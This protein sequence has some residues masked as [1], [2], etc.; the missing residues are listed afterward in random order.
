MVPKAVIAD[1]SPDAGD[2]ESSSVSTSATA[3]SMGRS[4]SVNSKLS[5]A[6]PDAQRKKLVKAFLDSNGFMHVNESKSS[7]TRTC[8]PLHTAVRQNKPAIVKALL[9]LGARA[10]LKSRGLTPEEY[11]LQRQNKWGGYEGTVDVFKQFRDQEISRQ[12]IMEDSESSGSSH[13]I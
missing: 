5:E 10:D 2:A 3:R 13:S 9:L 11:A 6:D 7:W 12:S 8:Y 4:S 1:L